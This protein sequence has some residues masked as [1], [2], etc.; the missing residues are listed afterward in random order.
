MGYF[1]GY[2]QDVPGP[3]MQSLLQRTGF[4]DGSDISGSTATI[5]VCLRKVARIM[6]LLYVDSGISLHMNMQCKQLD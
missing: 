2:V 5:Q 4:T 6:N 3:G 1:D